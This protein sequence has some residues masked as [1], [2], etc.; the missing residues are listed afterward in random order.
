M[1]HS[2]HND[3]KVWEIQE[4]EAGNN[5]KLLCDHYLE[6]IHAVKEWCNSMYLYY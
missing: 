6:D 3:R 1:L 4:I 5:A 2:K